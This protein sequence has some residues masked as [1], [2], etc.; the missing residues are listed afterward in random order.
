MFNGYRVSDL[1]DSVSQQCEYTYW[2]V[3]LKMAKMQ[4]LYY[5]FFYH[6]FFKKHTKKKW[7]MSSKIWLGTL[8]HLAQTL[9][10]LDKIFYLIFLKMVSLLKQVGSL[11]KK[12]Y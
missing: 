6:S 4:I 2:T 11:T 9:C 3:H 5:M 10:S 7:P 12:V 8:R 1:Q